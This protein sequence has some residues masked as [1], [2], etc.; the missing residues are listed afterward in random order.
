MN[1]PT[2]PN[3]HVIPVS[4][5]EAKNLIFGQSHFIKTVEDIHEALITSVPNIQFGLAF[6]E[7]SGPRLIRVSGTHQG[8]ID[9]A[10]KNAM[11]IGCGH[12]FFL[13]LENVFPINILPAIKVI[14]EIVR[15]FC[16]TANP[17]EVM[18]GETQQGRGV[19]G[20]IDGN[21]PLGIEGP[22]D[23][24]KRKAFLRDIGYKL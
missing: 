15:I 22:N 5:P 19:L 2:I 3:I 4:N 17:V 10:Q 6:C 11:E 14:P 23:I 8:M 7:A 13:F 16:A 1:V 21:S 20:V 12:T 18:V 9:L 24:K